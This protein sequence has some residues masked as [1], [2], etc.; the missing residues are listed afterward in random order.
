MGERDRRRVYSR[1]DDVDW[2]N[3]TPVE[4]ATLLFVVRDE[5]ILLI[6]K[7]RGIGAGKINGP[8]GRI[9]PDESPLECAIREV[10][11]ELSVTPT[12]VRSCGEV[13][14]Q[15]CDGFSIQIF[16][17]TAD[18]CEG[19]PRETEEA[20]PLWAP[21]GQIPYDRMWADD[22]HWIPLMLAGKRFVNR[23]LFDGDVLLG[24]ELTTHAAEPRASRASR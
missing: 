24:H 2:A 18:G 1:F 21:L 10:R 20:K 14:F 11:E 23:V 3:W 6:H 7:K 9:E 17:F 12:G 8:G 19:E 5:R 22:I 4:R 15:V 13:L 16:V